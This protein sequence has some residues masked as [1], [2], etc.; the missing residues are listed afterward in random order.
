MKSNIHFIYCPEIGN[1]LP[2]YHLVD[3]SGVGILLEGLEDWEEE[4]GGLIDDAN[5]GNGLLDGKG[6]DGDHGQTAVLDLG[7]LHPLAT[8]LGLGVG[9]EGVEA[10][11]AGGGVV[12]AL[13]AHDAEGIDG[14]GEGEAGDPVGGVDLAK[15]TVEEGGGAVGGIHDGGQVEGGGNF[16]VENLRERPASGGEHG[17]SGVLDCEVCGKG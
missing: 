15:S 13:G 2:P 4:E 10:Q 1:V 14:T 16:L 3:V 8:V 9:T 17:K 6:E 11:I 12:T 5:L 7:S